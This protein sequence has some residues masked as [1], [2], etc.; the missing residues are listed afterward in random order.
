MLNPKSVSFTTTRRSRRSSSLPA[1]PGTRSSS[2]PSVT[3]KFSGLM[4]RWNTPRSWHAATA[5]HICLNMLAISFNRVRESSFVGE[6]VASSDG[7]GGVRAD[8]SVEAEQTESAGDDTGCADGV[9]GE[10]G[11]A[12]S[13]GDDGLP[14]S[15]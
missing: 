6:S 1:G 9:E 2:T 8:A 12:G 4:S 10:S 13:A 5:S 11:T 7:V 15:Q 3:M 14:M